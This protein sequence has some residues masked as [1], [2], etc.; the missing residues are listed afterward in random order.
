MLPLLCI[1]TLIVIVKIGFKYQ[2]G[3]DNG[4]AL[5]PAFI[6]A[7]IWSDPPFTSP[8]RAE[9]GSS[10]RVC[11]RAYLNLVKLR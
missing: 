8:N 1:R 3:N 4:C 2:M 7:S 5:M 11:M 9:M 6:T 10:V